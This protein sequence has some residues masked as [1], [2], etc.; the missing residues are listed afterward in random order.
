MDPLFSEIFRNR[1]IDL[2]DAVT[3]RGQHSSVRLEHRQPLN[4]RF[5]DLCSVVILA[6]SDTG[7]DISGIDE[8]NVETPLRLSCR[9]P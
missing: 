7:C 9:Q 6:V 4:R 1:L 3:D 8:S 2:N 5:V